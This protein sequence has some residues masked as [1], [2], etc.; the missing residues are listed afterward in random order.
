MPGACPWV[1]VAPEGNGVLGGTRVPQG[2][3]GAGAACRA[4]TGAH[5]SPWPGTARTGRH[6]APL[7]GASQPRSAPEPQSIPEPPSALSIGKLRHGALPHL[8]LMACP[9]PSPAP[10]GFRC[11]GGAAAPLE[12]GLQGDSSIRWGL[13]DTVETPAGGTPLSLAAEWPGT[14]WGRRV[15]GGCGLPLPLHAGRRFCNLASS[16]W[17]HKV[18]SRGKRL[19]E[20]G[21]G[22]AAGAGKRSPGSPSGTPGPRPAT[23]HSGW[24]LHLSWYPGTF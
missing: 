19:Q 15:A 17:R 22:A 24:H 1:Q 4:G 18:G 14:S 21:D 6:E 2:Y 9:P 7:C 13:G 12:G 23:L 16:R 8:R 10:G 20:M 11:P 5:G 3:G